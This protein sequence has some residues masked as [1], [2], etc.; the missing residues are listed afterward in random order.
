ML[1]DYL[2]LH[3]G[4]VYTGSYFAAFSLVALWEA[5]SPRRRLTQPMG[6]R[7]CANIAITVINIYFT[8]LLFPLAPV[9]VA[10]YASEHHFGLFNVLDVPV[11]VSLA[12]SFALLDLSN[13]TFHHLEHRV[14]LLWR[15]HAVHHS[16]PD[17]D[18][19]TALRFHP[20]EALLTVVVESLVILLIGAP[21]IAVLC[22]KVVQVF[23]AA[24]AH[25]NLKLPV[26]ADRQLRKLLVTPDLHRIHHSASPRETN[27]NYGGI[28]PW[29]DRVFGTYVAQP[30]AGHENLVMG[31]DGMQNIE[32]VK[33][34]RMLL[35]PFTGNQPWLFPVTR[36]SS[37]SANSGS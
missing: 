19:S 36:L 15:L 8:R 35:Q 34:H 29:W 5:I 20:L 33:L 24:F 10:L 22:Y 14:R 28:T 30:L 13:W 23:M 26:R 4:L 25:G 16:D 11:L 17:Y 32:S 18:F 6:L 3:Q 1:S 21:A 2:L 12:A 31:L 7:W 27:S 9:F 37:N